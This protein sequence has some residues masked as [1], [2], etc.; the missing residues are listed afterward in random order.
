MVYI[1][2]VLLG[3]NDLNSY[4]EKLGVHIP[5]TPLHTPTQWSA[6]IYTGTFEKLVS[7]NV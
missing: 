4:K 5:G 1:H 2:Q 6:N 3:N 7:G